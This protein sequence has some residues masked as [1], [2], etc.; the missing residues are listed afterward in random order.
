M[1][2]Y[3]GYICPWV[4]PPEWSCWNI[5][6]TEASY[7]PGHWRQMPSVVEANTSVV[8]DL[9]EKYH[10]GLGKLCDQCRQCY[11]YRVKMVVNRRGIQI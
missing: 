1:G 7:N 8:F 3:K 6:A 4:K 5:Y 10:Q 9:R 2:S 11:L